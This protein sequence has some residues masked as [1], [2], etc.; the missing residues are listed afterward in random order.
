MVLKERQAC[1]WV[2][3]YQNIL[4]I[5]IGETIYLKQN[6]FYF[7][8]RYGFPNQSIHICLEQDFYL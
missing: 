8:F 2:S 4:L 6:L 7:G 5:K 1:P 3:T